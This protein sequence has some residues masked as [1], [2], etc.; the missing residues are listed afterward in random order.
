MLFASP[1]ALSTSLALISFASGTLGKACVKNTTAVRHKMANCTTVTVGDM[2]PVPAL[3]YI[4]VENFSLTC[5]RIAKLS[6]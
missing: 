1:N 2:L 6:R 4:L 5:Q 3:Q